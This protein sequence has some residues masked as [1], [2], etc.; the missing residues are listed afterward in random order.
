MLPLRIPHEIHFRLKSSYPVVIRVLEQQDIKSLR[1]GFQKLSAASIFSR[2]LTPEKRLNP[3]ELHGMLDQ[4]STQK[5]ILG[6]FGT[7]GGL[8]ESI[9]VAEYHQ[10]SLQ[11]GQAEMA[12]TIIDEYQNQGLG[13]CFLQ[14]LM[15]AGK[16]AGFQKFSGYLLEGNLKMKHILNKFNA[17]FKWAGGPI[18][19]FELPVL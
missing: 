5:L 7:K 4:N 3:D 11:P 2:F 6:A 13:T 10:D 8:C 14:I 17:V 16:L 12:V 15:K 18:L 19:R 1:E 9:G